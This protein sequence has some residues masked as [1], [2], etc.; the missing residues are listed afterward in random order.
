MIS[1]QP[2]KKKRVKSLGTEGE[3]NDDVGSSQILMRNKFKHECS[4]LSSKQDFSE[5]RFVFM[6][7]VQYIIT[8][9]T[10]QLTALFLKRRHIRDKEKQKEEL[11]GAGDFPIV[12]EYAIKLDRDI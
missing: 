3:N 9:T 8:F 1:E 7:C 4:R 5:Q 12:G 10:N 11:L 6:K 2:N